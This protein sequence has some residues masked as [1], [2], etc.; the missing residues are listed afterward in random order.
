MHFV[1]RP[2]I[3]VFVVVYFDDILVFSKSLK[4]HV[5]HLRTVLQTLRKE[6]LYANM[7]KCL[8]GVDKLVFLGFVVSSKG[9]HVDES[10]INAIKTWPQPTNLQQVHSFLTLAGFYHRFVKEFST[11]ASPLRYLSKKMRH[12]FG[13]HPKIPHLMSLRICLLMLPWLH[14]PTLTNLLEFMEM[15]AVMA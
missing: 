6:C 9:V 15:L 3:S 7:D 1:L 11:I 10:K 2:Y 14:Y 4:Y 12:L 5:T 8:F 13:D